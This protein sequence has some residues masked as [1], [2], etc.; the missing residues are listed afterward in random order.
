MFHASEK[1]P[2]VVKQP[3]ALVVA[4]TA[5]RDELIMFSKKNI[6]NAFAS[7]AQQPNSDLSIPQ[8]P[9]STIT[10]SSSTAA[11]SSSSLTYEN[12]IAQIYAHIVL[13]SNNS[14]PFNSPVTNPPII[15][16]AY[17]TQTSNYP[18]KFRDTFVAKTQSITQKNLPDLIESFKNIPQEEFNVYDEQGQTLAHKLTPAH[19][20]PPLLTIGIEKGLDFTK[21]SIAPDLFPGSTL[22]HNVA[23]LL[24]SRVR[25]QN[26]T[27][28]SERLTLYINRSLECLYQ[29][30]QIDHGA[31]FNIDADRKT[32]LENCSVW[33]LLHRYNHLMIFLD[34]LND[35]THVPEKYRALYLN[36]LRNK[37]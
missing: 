16:P 1:K 23:G 21:P 15:R 29:L 31:H 12:N 24:N 3:S 30:W 22:A 14:S 33:D 7:Q 26:S 13:H 17:Q 35:H 20:I 32:E 27:Q 36:Y 18:L 28:N 11:L 4:F 8:S 10:S 6:S 37:Q 9:T 34:K 5:H 19:W 25:L 2:L